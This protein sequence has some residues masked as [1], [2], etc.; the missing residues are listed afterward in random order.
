MTRQRLRRM[1]RTLLRE[2]QV[3]AFAELAAEADTPAPGSP[4]TAASPRVGRARRRSMDTDSTQ[5]DERRSAGSTS[6]REPFVIG[7]SYEQYVHA[8]LLTV[9]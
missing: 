1:A 4:A 5:T 6:N 8:A 2:A 3:E 7:E 9:L